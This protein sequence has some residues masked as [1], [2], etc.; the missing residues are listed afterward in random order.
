M[1]SETE[2]L[3]SL[4][5]SVYKYVMGIKA[6]ICDLKKAESHDDWTNVSPFHQYPS[7]RKHNTAQQDDRQLHYA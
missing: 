1:F 7:I 3:L 6:E 2:I 4:P 5:K